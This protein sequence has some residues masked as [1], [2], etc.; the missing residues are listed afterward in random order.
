MISP[1][2]MICTR[3]SVSCRACWLSFVSLHASAPAVGEFADGKPAGLNT[4]S[5]A[6]TDLIRGDKLSNV[7]TLTAS[8]L[9]SFFSERLQQRKFMSWGILKVFFLSTLPIF[10]WLPKYA[11]KN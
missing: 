5:T 6:A 4:Y 7:H 1:S 3:C 9:G 10:T 8:V 2:C 11:A